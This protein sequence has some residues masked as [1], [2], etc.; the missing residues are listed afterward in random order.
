MSAVGRRIDRLAFRRE[1]T[2]APIVGAAA[3]LAGRGAGAR[4]VGSLSQGRTYLVLT[5]V[6]VAAAVLQLLLAA[7]DEPEA[8]ATAALLLAFAL[9]TVVSAA[10]ADRDL[11]APAAILTSIGLVSFAFGVTF[12]HPDSAVALMIPVTGFIVALPYVRGGRMV[13]LGAFVLAVTALVG[14]RVAVL[15]EGSLAS[16]SLDV[17]S[18]AVAVAGVLMLLTWRTV[19][20]GERL[21]TRMT[22]LV[23]GVPIGIFKADAQGVL[24]E[25]NGPLVR[26][27]G[28]RDRE[29]LIGRRSTDLI[30]VPTPDGALADAIEEAGAKVGE[31]ELLR[32]DGS[33]LWVR[34]HV[35]I[36]QNQAGAV[37]GYEGVLEDVSADRL[38]RE[39]TARL[40]AWKQERA[41]I[42]DRLRRLSPGRT[43]EETADAICAELT[44]GEEVQYAA[45]LE[46]RNGHGATFVA[47]RTGRR[48]VAAGTPVAARFAAELRRRAVDG[49]WVEDVGSRRAEPGYRRLAGIGIEQ[50]ALVPIEIGGE[51]VGLLMA[52]T[53]DA[54]RDLQ[55]RLH[56]LGEFAMHASALIGPALTARHEAEVLRDRIRDV[57]RS[58]AFR[59][60]FQAIVDLESGAVLGYEALTRFDDG[61]PPDRMFA[62]AAGS[63]IGVE[64]EVATI[65][66]ALDASES[67]P[68]NHF[69]DLNVSPELVLAEEPLRSMLRE[70]G[71]NIVVELT[72][73]TAIED[74]AEVRAAIASLGGHVQLAVDDAGAGFASLR[75]ITELRPNFVKLDRAIIRGIG[76]DLV[77]QAMVTGMVHFTESV[78]S[79]LIAE[80]V[81]TEDERRTLLGLGVT[82]AQG[83]LFG[84][85]TSADAVQR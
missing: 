39:A 2:F 35:R 54:G 21:A 19:R 4:A 41:E 52:G 22:A 37:T 30:A 5:A 16:L 72:E 48:R 31:L 75:H 24:T 46:L 84:R 15:R 80:G 70:R 58:R 40:A 57:I 67:L 33:R 68:A 10:L 79:M 45:I 18:G 83:Y 20:G 74:Y 12:V 77:R 63:G 14:W 17:A 81:E 50:V 3:S 55:E 13:V 78:G 71:F 49:P 66:A 73:H 85:P 8:V 62:D 1:P 43:V 6:A 28:Y 82:C 38:A 69:I 23:E 34:Y 60:V 64:L 9:V 65:V 76:E 25:V 36:Q 56:T 27:L 26:L 44:R 11:P 7:T 47:D 53:S 29:A 32:S 51:I 61:T 42:L 59:P